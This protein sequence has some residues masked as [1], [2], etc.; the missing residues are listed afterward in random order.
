M[1]KTR[2]LKPIKAGYDDNKLAIYPRTVSR[3]EL[4]D[5]EQ[6]L[7]EAS[8]E[9]VDKYQKAFEIKRQAIG[10]WSDGMPAEIVR[11]KGEDTLVP[12]GEGKDI[13]SAVN[14]YFADRSIEAEHIVNAI[15]GAFITLQ[16]PSVDFL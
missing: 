13:A 5:V 14:A 12:I 11:D 7:A 4:D 15:Y 2:K 8:A 6:Q 9:T 3:A 10:D 1:L 16:V